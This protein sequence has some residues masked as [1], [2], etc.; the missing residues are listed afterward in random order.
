M[1]IESLVKRLNC[2]EEAAEHLHNAATILCYLPG[3]YES[4]KAQQEA[5]EEFILQERRRLEKIIRESGKT[6]SKQL[7]SGASDDLDEVIWYVCDGCI[8][9]VT[10]CRGI[11]DDLRL[12]R[13]AD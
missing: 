2:S 8:Y 3:M 7:C 10:Y 11:V 9:R 1:N 4:I 5:A 6:T 13:I 12:D